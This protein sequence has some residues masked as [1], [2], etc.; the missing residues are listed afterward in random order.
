MEAPSPPLGLFVCLLQCQ[1]PASP[2]QQGYTRGVE[3]ESCWGVWPFPCAGG[4]EW[5]P[6]LS[7]EGDLSRGA[8]T[9]GGRKLGD[10]KPTPCRG[11]DK[12]TLVCVSAR[13]GNESHHS[14]S[15]W[16]RAHVSSPASARPS[17]C[18][19]WTAPSIARVS[20]T[21]C[22]AYRR[23]DTRVVWAGGASRGR[24]RGAF[25]RPGG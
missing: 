18:E 15:S 3:H 7:P 23:A 12:E 25:P 17:F 5:R 22:L 21:A 13:H 16:G 6:K 4:R 14:Q 9:R 1:G 11:G 19:V 24:G 10:C 8:K 20:V 2:L